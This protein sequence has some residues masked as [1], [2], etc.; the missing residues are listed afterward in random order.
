MF[1]PPSAITRKAFD[2]DNW[3]ITWADDGEQCIAYGDG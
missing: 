3:P 1:D 2:S